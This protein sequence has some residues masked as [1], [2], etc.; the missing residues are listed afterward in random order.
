MYKCNKCDR[1]FEKYASLSKHASRTHNIKFEE[2]Y[3]EYNLNGIWP[4]C[5]CGCNQKVKWSYQLKSFRDYCQGHQSR[6]KNNWGH[7]RKAI[8]N[9]AKTRKERFANGMIKTWNDGLTKDTNESVKM[10][11]KLRSLA[12]TPEIKNEYSNRM[13][14][15]RISGII[16]TLHGKDHSQWKGGT[17]SINVLVRARTKLYK[18]WKYPILCRDGFKC[19]KCGNGKDLHVHHDKELMSEIIEKHIIDDDPK[20]FD[21]KEVIADCV[22]DYHIKNNVSGITLCRECHGKI[23][24]SLNF[25]V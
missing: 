9:S 7:N 13:K 19:V 2:F 17:S 15:Q 25:S 6:I 3:V 21:M 8:E 11:G 16:P 4:L 23:H 5:K 14:Q 10:C 22:V 12:F 20:T 24:P 1:K 18:E